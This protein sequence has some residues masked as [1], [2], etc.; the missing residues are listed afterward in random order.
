MEFKDADVKFFLAIVISFDVRN[1]N[2]CT[3]GGVCGSLRCHLPLSI[4]SQQSEVN[5]H[6]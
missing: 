4:T 5:L 6:L 3:S 2:E 1:F